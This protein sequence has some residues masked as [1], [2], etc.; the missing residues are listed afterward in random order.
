MTISQYLPRWA[1]WSGGFAV[2]HLSLFAGLRNRYL[3]RVYNPP[4]RQGWLFRSFR[5]YLLGK[6]VYRDLPEFRTAILTGE[7]GRR[8]ADFYRSRPQEYYFEQFSAPLKV[9]SELLRSGA[10][11]R[12]LQ[13]GCAGGRELAIL[14]SRFPDLKFRGLDINAA[15][16]E[17][18][19]KVYASIGNLEFRMADVTGSDSWLEWH[20]DIIYSSGCL[21]YLTEDEVASFMR[22][23]NQFWLSRLILCEPADG[24]PREHSVPRGGGAFAHD[25]RHLATRGGWSEI[26]LIC[27][28]APDKNLLLIASRDSSAALAAVNG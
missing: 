24:N 18:N 20:P 8:W 10:G 4:E 23:A 14:A 19:R 26:S 9:C 22:R 12:F 15:A 2:Y 3:E 6:L 25:Y 28:P 17:E 7:A 16:I 21:E 11:R 5:G 27:A 1:K 13:I